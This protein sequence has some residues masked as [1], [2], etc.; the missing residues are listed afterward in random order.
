LK[1]RKLSEDEFEATWTP[2]MHDVTANPAPTIDIWPYVEAVLA[3]DLDGH[4]VWD[5]FAEYVY[6]TNDDRFDHVLVMTKSKNVYLA[7]IIDREL[8]AV[9]GHHLLNMN[10]LY[11]LE[12]N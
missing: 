7:V 6:R 11:G 8:R 4:E 2:K 9:H 5:R 10:K 3:A 12:P 1:V